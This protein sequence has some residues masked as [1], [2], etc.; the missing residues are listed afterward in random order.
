MT[1]D[2]PTRVPRA[3]RRPVPGHL[4]TFAGDLP[5]D[6]VLR[7]AE[8]RRRWNAQRGTQVEVDAAGPV[9]VDELRRKLADAL[10]EVERR[11]GRS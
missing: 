11:R 4:G 5:D 7:E 6:P 8:A 3:R 10:A 2:E 9:D 1:D